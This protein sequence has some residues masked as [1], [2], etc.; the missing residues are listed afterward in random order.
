MNIPD[1]WL[2]TALTS[3][4]SILKSGAVSLPENAQNVHDLRQN[5]IDMWVGVEQSVID[6]GIDQWCRRLHVCIRATGG[7]FKYLL[8]R[9]LA[10]ILLAVNNK[11][12]FII[13]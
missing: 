12:K 7:H 4:H 3:V 13:K 6:D 10:K 2:W 1:F 5:M 11:F 9:I 8:W